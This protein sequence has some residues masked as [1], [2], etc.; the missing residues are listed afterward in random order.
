MKAAVI[1]TLIISGLAGAQTR[2]E[3]EAWQTSKYLGIKVKA[4]PQLTG[5]DDIPASSSEFRF[6]LRRRPFTGPP[7][8]PSYETRELVRAKGPDGIMYEAY[9]GTYDEKKVWPGS[10]WNS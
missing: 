2:V 7:P 4:F 6:R 1:L 3:H 10:G 8:P 5:Y 9:S